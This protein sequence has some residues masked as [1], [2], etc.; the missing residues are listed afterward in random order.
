M[1]NW[2]FYGIFC[3]WFVSGYSAYCIGVY[4]MGIGAGSLV[5]I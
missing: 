2:R 4:G 3:V 1:K 5:G